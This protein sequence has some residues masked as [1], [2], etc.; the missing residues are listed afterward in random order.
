VRRTALLRRIAA[1]ALLAISVAGCATAVHNGKPVV[2]LIGDSTV[3]A[4]K[5]WG[6]GFAELL[7]GRATVYNFAVGGR[8]ARSYTDEN[9]LPAALAVEPD[10]VFIQFGHNGQPG[11]G[12]YRETDP[13]GSYRDYLR[14]FVVAIR[15]AGA[16]P[17]IV[18]SLTRR[19][20]NQAGRIE[21]TLGPWADG[22]RAVAGELDVAFIDLHAAS[23]ALHDRLGE[24]KS[25]AFD[26]EPGDRTHL[27]DDGA[28]EIAGLILVLLAEIGHP[29][30]DP[31][32]GN[33]D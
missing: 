2:A 26:Y 4:D 11:K 1:G 24:Q 31:K 9:R 32:A 17:I 23:I 18:S 22:A 5:G 19:H 29:L 3:T 10:Y 33:P 20:F 6:G 15:A 25:A 27:N 30:G 21:S 13:D 16:E 28:R 8:S 7:D 12:A 14:D